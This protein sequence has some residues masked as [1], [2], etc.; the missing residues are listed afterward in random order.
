MADEHAV[1]IT[2]RHWEVFNHRKR[3]L[4][5][6][7]VA[8]LMRCTI[9]EV[10]VLEAEALDEVR[11]EKEHSTARFR[12]LELAKLDAVV[13]HMFDWLTSD[14]GRWATAAGKV[15]TNSVALRAKLLGLEMP[16]QI[17]AV[18][19][20]GTGALVIGSEMSMDELEEGFQDWHVERAEHE[21]R[22]LEP[23]VEEQDLT[24]G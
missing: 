2:E 3:G 10:K 7:D 5:Y 8:T 15:I 11:A 13:H 4:G 9:K 16:K 6:Q 12:T 21:A 18:V 14:E 23:S 19:H 17:E 20:E 24:E 22:L 1:A